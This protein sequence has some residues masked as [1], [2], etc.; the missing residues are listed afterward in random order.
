MPSSDPG[1]LSPRLTTRISHDLGLQQRGWQGAVF[2]ASPALPR[3][4]EMHQNTCFGFK[5]V[6]QLILFLLDRFYLT[7]GANTNSHFLSKHRA[8]C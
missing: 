8:A 6:S 4:V 2:S 7:A 3:K 5:D 1:E